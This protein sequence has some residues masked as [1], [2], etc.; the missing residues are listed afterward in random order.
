MGALRTV[1]CAVV[2]GGHALD[3]V[4]YPA[5][6]DS[7]IREPVWIVAPPRSGTT[8]MH[9]LMALDTER[10]TSM[11]LAQTLFPSVT[12]QHAGRA[13]WAAHRRAGR[14]G[15]GGLERLEQ[16][17]FRGWT[18]IHP[19]GFHEPEED[20]ALFVYAGASPAFFLMFPSLD[21]PAWR[22]VDALP[23]GARARVMAF[24]TGCLRRHSFAHGRGRQLL[25]KSTL[26]AARLDALLE[27]MPHA[28][29]VHLVRH[30]YETVP[31]VLSMFHVAWHAHLPAMAKDAPEVRAMARL[32]MKYARRYA[33]LGSTLPPERFVTVHYDDLVADPA[34]AVERVYEQLQM[35]MG[36]A[37]RQRLT[38]AARV[39]GGHR[40][41][42]RYRLE[43]F[44][45]TTND[46][47]DAL[48]DWMDRHG[49]ARRP[50]AA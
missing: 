29:F 23:S 27:A 50:R 6:R 17:L 35:T 12:L 20:E 49:F 36:H 7:P 34:R 3:D 8:L 24:H 10:F 14:P 1:F 30:P 15:A 28:R 4:L 22:S 48:G 26:A 44:G 39:A 5:W 25:F 41:A 47:D 13:A 18:G 42:H 32:I 16:R 46:V 40:S 9:R 31:S 37:F 45:L 11:T 38:Q 19:M 33:E 2:A 43:D 21:V